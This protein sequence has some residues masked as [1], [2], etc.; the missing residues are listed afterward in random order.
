MKGGGD[1]QVALCGVGDADTM[2]RV[3]SRFGRELSC[4]LGPACVWESATPF[5]APRFTK[6]RGKDSL[7]NQIREGLAR[8]SFPPSEVE[9]LRTCRE[10]RHVVLHDQ[11]QSP[12]MQIGYSIRLTFE[13][14]T[15]GPVCLGYGS[16]FGLGRFRAV[17]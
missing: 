3:G 9:V 11:K 5:V 12:P 6:R 2:T 16:H 17:R 13:E 1:L 14:E 10:F 8:R 4:A 7:E 15:L